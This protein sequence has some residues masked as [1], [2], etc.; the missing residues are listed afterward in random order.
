VTALAVCLGAACGAASGARAHG[1]DPA[2]LLLRETAPHVWAVTWQVSALRLPGADVQPALP[3]ACRRLDGG[4]VV[5]G[6]DRI[7]LRW[8]VDCGPEGLAG[9]TIGVT[10]LAAAKINALVRIAGLDGSEQSTVLSPRHPSFRVPARPS[11]WEVV[12]SY[13]RLGVEHI[14]SGPDHL[15]FVLGLVLLVPGARMLVKTITAFTV[16]HSITLSA[17]VLQVV[18]VPSRP[19]EVLIALSVLVVAVE[20]AGDG[21][22]TGIRRR[23]WLLAGLFGLLHGFGFAGALAEAGLPAGVVP[24]ALG[25][26]NVGIEA[27]QLAVVALALAVRAVVRRWS[28][29]VAARAFRPAVYAMGILAA[30]WSFERVAAWL[31]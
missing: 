15:L 20:L 7:T 9:A 31:G 6:G 3:P 21:G 29:A 12:R 16:G 1:L 18:T 23:P 24:L 14:A 22:A 25:A 26:F 4:E 27:G 10:D 30:F 11:A 19:V 2:S 17:A 28:P 5:D 13:G 8:T